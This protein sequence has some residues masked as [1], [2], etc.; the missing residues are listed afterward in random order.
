MSRSLG[1]RAVGATLDFKFNTHSAD[2][3]PIT[4]AGTPAVSVYKDNGATESTAG[5]TLTVDQDSRTGMHHVRIV[6]TD[7]FYAAGSYQVVIT[8]GTVDG[9]S[10]V[11]VQVA[12]FTLGLIQ[13]SNLEQWLGV[14]PDQLE[15]AQ[16]VADAVLNADNSEYDEEGSVGANIAAGASGGGGGGATPEQIWG[17]SNR[18]LSAGGVSA[19]QSGLATESNFT[20]VG[21]AVASLNN[22][23]ATQAQ[24][25]A[26]AA[27][28]AYDPPTA[29]EMND[30]TRLSAEYATAASQAPLARLDAMLE[31]DG[32][33][34]NRFT[35][36]AL[37]EGPSGDAEVSPEQIAEIRDGLATEAMLQDV[38]S[39]I[40][41][42]LSNGRMA[43]DAQQI[44][45]APV[46]GSGTPDDKWRGA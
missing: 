26:A 34:G 28:T 32:D 1:N 44:N 22:L 12:D 45:S 40:P 23:S 2:G 43:S 39:R 38:S 21:V 8:A 31:P 37:S 14:T 15:T 10:V 27:L 9:T 11:G 19:I 29:A 24:A 20:A 42:E 41:A 33:G 25:A 6:T 36:G 46:V 3:A 4:L 5:V 35:A 13:A 18:T 7:S 30:R 17:H 16:D